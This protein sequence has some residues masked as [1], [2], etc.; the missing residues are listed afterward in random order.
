MN[1]TKSI[2]FSILFIFL[3]GFIWYAGLKP[4]Y[5]N[6]DINMADHYVRTGKCKEALDLM[7]SKV[8][9]NPSTIDSYA[10]LKYISIIERCNA[11]TPE[12]IELL[13]K[14]TEIRP[15]Y[16]RTWIFLGNYTG[17]K[18][19][20][21][22]ASELS[23]KREEIFVGRIKI[24]MALKNYP[25]VLSNVEECINISPASRS[26][27]WSKIISNFYLNDIKQ[28][29]IDIR[30]AG[31][32]DRDFSTEKYLSQIYNACETNNNLECYEVLFYIIEDRLI[33]E[34]LG[35]NFP[36]LESSYIDIAKKINKTDKAEEFLSHP[37]FN[38]E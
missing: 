14:V 31:E 3:L 17:D 21:D 10:K 36:Y 38:K 28:A 9:Y 16:T 12:A 2:I 13:K 26:C 37:R 32:R 11:R 20:F 22:K 5:I 25:L 34:R 18:S 23:P 33:A 7:R 6:K 27:W 15:Y 35:E 1:P 19:Y 29:K 24:N 8:I 30:I 4:L